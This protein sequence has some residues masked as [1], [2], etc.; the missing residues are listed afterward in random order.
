MYWPEVIILI[1]TLLVGSLRL[2]FGRSNST[3]F[4]FGSA[5]GFVPLRDGI[6]RLDVY[7]LL[8]SYIVKY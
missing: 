3:N 4:F 8:I 5:Y 1:R 6:L 2:T 7:Y